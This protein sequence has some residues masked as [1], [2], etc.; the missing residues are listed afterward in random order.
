[1]PSVLE[2]GEGGAGSWR[3]VRG[4]WCWRN[5]RTLDGLVQGG[6]GADQEADD[7]SVRRGDKP[8]DLLLILWDIGYFFFRMACVVRDCRGF[9]RACVESV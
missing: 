1:M 8:G 9:G 7:A 6:E 4:E 3:H 2:D 5:S